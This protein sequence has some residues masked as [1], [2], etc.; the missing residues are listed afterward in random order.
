MVFSR[1]KTENV[2]RKYLIL[3]TI[4]YIGV[5][6]NNEIMYRVDRVIYIGVESASARHLYNRSKVYSSFVN[7]LDGRSTI[8]GILYNSVRK[9]KGRLGINVNTRAAWYRKPVPGR[10]GHLLTVQCY[11]SSRNRCWAMLDKPC[12][13]TSQ[14]YK[15]RFLNPLSTSFSHSERSYF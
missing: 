11:Y 7:N 8:S 4:S 5:H 14:V 9:C 10:I 13:L 12:T 6:A 15:L 2:G 3:S 1:P